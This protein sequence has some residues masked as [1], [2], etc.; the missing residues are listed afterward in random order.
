MDTS[1]VFDLGQ[2][3]ITLPSHLVIFLANKSH[4][5]GYLL[6]VQGCSRWDMNSNILSF[7]ESVLNKKF[8]FIFVKLEKMTSNVNLCDFIKTG[9]LFSISRDLHS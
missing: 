1:I 9:S 6:D 8:L 2:S 7:P 5:I 3:K 4:L